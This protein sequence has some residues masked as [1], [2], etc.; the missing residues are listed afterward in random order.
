LPQ[1]IAIVDEYPAYVSQRFSIWNGDR[2][3]SKAW[4][5]SCLLGEFRDDCGIADEVQEKPALLT[6]G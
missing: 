5:G 4:S 3:A 6:S 1:G 2:A